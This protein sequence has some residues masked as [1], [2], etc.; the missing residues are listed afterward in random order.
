[1]SRCTSDSD[2]SCGWNKASG[3]NCSY[4]GGHRWY[5]IGRHSSSSVGS[6]CSS[7]M[8]KVVVKNVVIC[9]P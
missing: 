5:D 6:G 1:M 4:V 8:W 2:G 9:I 3:C 7:C